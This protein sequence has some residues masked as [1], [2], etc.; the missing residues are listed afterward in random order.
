MDINVNKSESI[1]QVGHTES[2]NRPPSQQQRHDVH[3]QQGGVSTL[4][5]EGQQ[6]SLPKNL[7][8]QETTPDGKSPAKQKNKGISFKTF[9]GLKGRKHTNTTG[10]ST[11]QASPSAR[12][13]L[14]G[15]SS[16]PS[17]EP[18]NNLKN[19][20]SESHSKNKSFV[21]K[22]ARGLG[23]KSTHSSVETKTSSTQ[24]TELSRQRTTL[25]TLLQQT[26]IYSDSD[27]QNIEQTFD[28][29]PEVLQHLQAFQR[30]SELQGLYSI[31]EED[32]SLD[33]DPVPPSSKMEKAPTSAGTDTK[34]NTNEI[35]RS[36][37]RRE[38]KQ[39]MFNPPF[40]I[41]NKENSNAESSRVNENSA[42][43]TP[44]TSPE[45]SH[46]QVSSLVSASP[47]PSMA[48]YIKAPVM[49]LQNEKIIF[50]KQNTPALNTL[51]EE[52][53]GKPTQRY[54]AHE[55]HSDNQ[56]QLLLDK[57]GRVF[58]VSTQTN[59]GLLAFHSSTPM[60]NASEPTPSLANHIEQ[61]GQNFDTNGYRP[62]V[63]GIHSDD[64]GQQW[65][66]S[67]NTLYSF[68]ELNEHD[69]LSGIQLWRQV[70]TEVS[71]LH[72]SS[73]GVLGIKAKDQ[74]VN[75]TT[76]QSSPK[77]DHEIKSYSV[78]SEGQVALLLNADNAPNLRLLPNL[79]ASPQDALNVE[80][81]YASPERRNDPVKLTEVHLSSNRL[82]AI[83]AENTVLS[84]PLPRPDQ[85]SVQFTELPQAELQN[86]FGKDVKFEGFTQHK[87]GNT[88]L[89]VRDHKNHLHGC[90]AIQTS[91]NT[92]KPGWNLSDTL[93]LSNTLGL[94][95]VDES[96]LQHQNF[97]KTG[98][99]ATHDGK[100]YSQD[101]L[102]Q[103]WSMV[104]DKI[105][106][107]QRGVDGQAYALQGG[108]LKKINVEEKSNAI[109]FGADNIFA[110]TQTRGTTSLSE[111]PKGLPEAPLKAA[112]VI[113]PY[114]HVTLS[115]T[116]TLQ[117]NHIRPGTSKPM[118]PPREINL[119][120]LEG[121][122][123]H[124]SIDRDHKL[125][126]ITDTG[127][128]FSLEKNDWQAFP[129][130]LEPASQWKEEKSDLF[131][132]G[133]KG[134]TLTLNQ[135]HRLEITN[136][137]I[138][139]FTLSEDGWK[140]S[141]PSPTQDNTIR[142][143]FFNNLALAS[144]GVKI[145]KDGIQYT[146]TAQAGGLL[147]METNKV[148]SKFVDRLKAHVFK[149][150]LEIPRPIMTAA[151]GVQHTWRGRDG[152]QSLYEQENA[153]YKEL[154]SSN[155][156]IKSNLLPERSN[157]D[158]KTR[159]ER[160]DLGP[161]GEPLKTALESLR[162]EIERSAEKQ[163][164][165]L[166]RHQGVLQNDNAAKLNLDYKPSKLKD[167]KQSL[168]PNRSG[169]NLSQEVL[170]NW[171]RNPASHDSNVNELLKSFTELNVNM[172]HQKTEIPLGRRRDPN[173]L[174]A[175]SKA[176][177][178][179]DTLTLQKLDNLIEKAELLSGRTP[180][181]HQIHTLQKNLSE[182]RDNSYENS[183]IK[184]YTDKGMTGHKDVEAVYNS[185]KSFIKAFSDPEHAVNIIMRAVFGSEDQN[186]FAQNLKELMHTLKPNDSITVSRG[187]NTSLSA[188]FIPN[189]MM[190]PALSMFPTIGG[191]AKRGY[192]I[193]ING[194]E[195]GVEIAIKGT[196]KGE[197][198]ANFGISKDTLPPMMDGHPDGF[199]TPINNDVTFRSDVLFGAG[200]TVNGGLSNQNEL[201]LNLRGNTIDAFV[202]GL[203]NGKISPEDLIDIGMEHTSMHGNTWN[204]NIDLAA[205]F[206][207]R[208]RVDYA[209]D[210]PTFLARAGGGL[211]ASVNLVSMKHD[212]LQYQTIETTKHRINRTDGLL[213]SA[214]AG[215]DAAL[216][217]GAYQE[218]EQGGLVMFSNLKSSATVAAN[219]SV[220]V[221]GELKTQEPS[222]I[223]NDSTK[224]LCDKLINAFQDPVSQQV[225]KSVVSEPF[226]I[227]E[228]L[229]I[230]DDHFLS[231]NIESAKPKNDQQ[232]AAINELQ[233]LQ[234]KH[235]A[236]KKNVNLMSDVKAVVAHSNPH[237]LDN[238]GILN[239][240]TSLVAP[241]QKD[242]LSA[243]ISE[244][245]EKDP[246]FS[247]M[248][249]TIR[250]KPNTYTWITL[251]LKDEPRLK[252]EK[253]FIEGKV[254]LEDARKLLADPE[255][256]RIKSISILE[257][258]QHQEGFNAPS[259]L[260]GGGSTAS[261]FMER[262]A[263]VINFNY[264]QDQDTPRNYAI[265]GDF[266]TSK[267]N[268]ANAIKELKQS[269]GLTLHA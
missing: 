54:V 255:L 201:K 221:R 25:A 261:V 219:N 179:L 7:T 254:T 30:R 144:K 159:I 61:S 176:R 143:T 19:T 137:S 88:S 112:A 95:I 257:T 34:S 244:M 158:V 168:N 37:P 77:L 50:D 10:P 36:T 172:S 16:N 109:G 97:G 71:H 251:Q 223:D 107:L 81:K 268:I 43:S 60:L 56:H 222:S 41:K 174:M 27:T 136:A 230:L 263:G 182:L 106:S 93:N 215:V 49:S 111:G 225:L 58:Q 142:D 211:N 199:K 216:T 260:V 253:E 47:E 89:I 190:I 129:K 226:D 212:N 164:T 2:P 154:E 90:P 96:V 206:T 94:D 231:G 53:L 52:T 243:Q 126:A 217:L 269:E 123:Q 55:S 18:L 220:K 67:G 183:R 100:L 72:E 264:G 252:L 13:N 66:I 116:G 151:Q 239:F 147:G 210:N 15:M 122:I 161:A 124:I 229:K 45:R 23:L 236:A 32:A 22:L 134:A 233:S 180:D 74:L 104:A 108:H 165:Q 4:A 51:L 240:L 148:S 128:L 162:A 149:P 11:Q 247:A 224:K 214:S 82:L 133:L 132:D 178:V 196:I 83:D 80:L 265:T 17:G 73:Q 232:Y 228:Q 139:K 101:K 258:G 14:R 103:Q 241:S 205:N 267:S 46:S 85:S 170:T 115:D 145:S 177:L 65:R 156:N 249:D 31:P 188:T 98:S 138:D 24:P 198:S 68:I 42:P 246:T 195:D 79:T 69:E 181:D 127:K 131:P 6:A 203:T 110:L 21:S 117:Y 218:H 87:D 28:E 38:G 8:Q 238:P 169:H 39:P 197:G 113:S 171:K 173:D 200:L 185:V 62:V 114:E 121:D 63:T 3:Q 187:Y 86:A 152:L 207:A 256:R 209:D 204:F 70:D 194:L 166:G 157:L 1:S 234:I 237:Q 35:E 59:M 186:Q 227:E 213:N 44:P 64:N 191:E 125:F 105:D 76:G 167:A 26:E 259:L 250:S 120:G 118:H 135:E 150:S 75:L 99:F 92:F 155:T 175:L 146:V 140:K 160:L 248:I 48:D 102:T 84:A 202:D 57:Q 78:N 20:S 153:L 12:N 189:K 119:R 242:A 5:S 130:A 192:D 9:L 193:E 141:T 184:H 29:D 262:E 163:L 235:L 245:M 208:A 266:A 40:E 91:G 33:E